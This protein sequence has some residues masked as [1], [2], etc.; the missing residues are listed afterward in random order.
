MKLNKV[1]MPWRL[2]NDLDLSGFRGKYTNPSY[3]V[4][5]SV[6]KSVD[7][8]FDDPEYKWTVVCDTH[9]YM[10]SSNTLDDARYL[11]MNSVQEGWCEECRYLE[12]PWIA[13][14]HKVRTLS[15]K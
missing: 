5:C 6:F 8:G 1:S 4:S 3:N 12:S 11:A 7:Q 9:G 10:I 13:S 15:E 14:I 2:K